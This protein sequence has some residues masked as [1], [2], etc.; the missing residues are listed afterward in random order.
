MSKLVKLINNVPNG[1]TYSGILKTDTDTGIFFGSKN[2]ILKTDIY[3][4]SV[5]IDS[6][7]YYIGFIDKNQ[8]NDIVIN[9]SLT[10]PECS[11]TEVDVEEVL[12]FYKPSGLFV[13]NLSNDSVIIYEKLF[14]LNNEN[15]VNITLDGNFIVNKPESTL[16][17]DK[18]NKVT[19][20]QVDNTVVNIN[21]GLVDKYGVIIATTDGIKVN[22]C[23]DKFSFL[24]S[25]GN[26]SSYYWY[27][28][29][30][31][32][33]TWINLKNIDS[34]YCAKCLVLSIPESYVLLSDVEFAS[35]NTTGLPVGYTRPQHSFSVYLQED[36]ANEVAWYSDKKE[37]I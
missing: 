25:N 22:T 26:I 37:F 11:E 9:D 8:S 24:Y 4:L 31:L 13:S 18:N 30:V 23:I 35:V 16:L 33:V 34:L 15:N 28:D 2:G 17:I 14:N 20:I 32:P 10:L 1:N 3:R 36:L 5:L 19:K 12:H 7:R 27:N 29:N 6:V 21:N